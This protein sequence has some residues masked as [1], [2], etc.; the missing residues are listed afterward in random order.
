MSRRIVFFA[1]CIAM[2]TAGSPRT[3]AFEDHSFEAV[4]A[5]VIVVR[6]LSFVAT[7]IGSALFVVSLP[8]ALVSRSTSQTAEAL[9]LRPGRATFTRPIGDLSSLVD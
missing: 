2:L 6:P 3:H 8:V 5:D 1:I 7:A 9:V 4:A